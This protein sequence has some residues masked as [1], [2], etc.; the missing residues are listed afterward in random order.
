MVGGSSTDSAP[1]MATFFTLLSRPAAR[2]RQS[3]PLDRCRSSPKRLACFSLIGTLAHWWIHHL[4]IQS[5]RGQDVISGIDYLYG[6]RDDGGSA[7]SWLYHKP[8]DQPGCVPQSAPGE[9][10]NCDKNE[11]RAHRVRSSGMK[12]NNF[13][14]LC[15]I[16]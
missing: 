12:R 1:A 5:W 4:Q 2:F 8:P 13:I 9:K 3:R 10:M 16:D 7:S 6:V 11:K 14:G 15:L